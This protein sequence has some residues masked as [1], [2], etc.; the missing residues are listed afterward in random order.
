MYAVGAQH[1]LKAPCI[2]ILELI[3][4]GD[5]VAVTSVEII[6]EIVHRYTALRERGRAVEIAR[7]FMQVV[8]DILPVVADDLLLALDLHLRH[9]SL[10]ARD[11]LYLAVMRNHGIAHIISADQHFDGI[12]GITRLDPGQWQPVS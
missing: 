5:I 12:D 10:P 1:H 7:L 9:I 11:S 8:P 2:A 6:Q 4:E 3:A